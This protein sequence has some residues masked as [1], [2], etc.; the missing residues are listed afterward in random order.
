MSIKSTGNR[1]QNHSEF[2][3]KICFFLVGFQPNASMNVAHHMLMY[4][5][6]DVGSTQPVWNCG[7]MAKKENDEEE[8]APPCRPGA[9][10]QVNKQKNSICNIKQNLHLRKLIL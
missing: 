8:T 3:F 5:C 10:Q 1:P 6:G 4:G 7:E 9:P 2:L